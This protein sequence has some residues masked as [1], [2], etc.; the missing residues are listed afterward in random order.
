MFDENL[1]PPSFPGGEQALLHFLAQ[2]IQYPTLARENGIQG[3]VALTFIVEIDGSI[4]TV[5][6]LRD[7][8]GGCGLESA[9]VVE[10][11]PNWKPGIYD[12]F[13]VRV[14]FTLPVRFKLEDSVPKK[15]K[16]KRFKDRGALIGN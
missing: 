12:G 1:Q 10:A 7:I 14:R 3:I 9:R 8:G 15:E 13:P 5:N 11:M 16:K 4:S 2:N 6:I